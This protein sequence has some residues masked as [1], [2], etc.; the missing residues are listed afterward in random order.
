MQGKVKG[1]QQTWVLSGAGY[2]AVFLLLG[3]GAP[4]SCALPSIPCWFGA[5]SPHRSALEKTWKVLGKERY[6]C[7][8]S[9]ETLRVE[10]IGPETF[11][12]TGWGRLAL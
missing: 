11:Q 12:T 6:V 9:M 7:C 3:Q 2:L 4:R 5:Q 8:P 1:A 10:G